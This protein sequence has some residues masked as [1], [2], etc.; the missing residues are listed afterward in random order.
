MPKCIRCG[1]KTATGQ[2]CTQCR[3]TTQSPIN[4][5]ILGAVGKLLL[6]EGLRLAEVHI[7]NRVQQKF[8]TAQRVANQITGPSQTPPISSSGNTPTW[9]ARSAPV[10]PLTAQA[11]QEEARERAQRSAE[12]LQRMM[13]SRHDSLMTIIGNIG[14]SS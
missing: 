14:R 9:Y 12:L 1:A 11:I 7:H 2:A 5:Q 3:A 10:D 4:S 8:A 6:K 13:Q